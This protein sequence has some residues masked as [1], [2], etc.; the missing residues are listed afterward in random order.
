MKTKKFIS[1]MLITIG[2]FTFISCSRMVTLVKVQSFEAKTSRLDLATAFNTV[3]MLLVDRGF[4]IKASNK[5]AGLIT[6]EYKKFASVGGDPP[7]DMYLQIKTTIRKLPKGEVVVKMSPI[8]KEQ[9]RLNAA[10]F[11]EHELTYYTG[12]QKNV[13]LIKS[14]RIKG[15]QAKGQVMFMNVVNDVAS[16]LGLSVD[17]IKQNITE[18]QENAFFK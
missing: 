3:T 5:E 14:M 6:T 16:A 8:V 4:D 11:T 17:D 7:F 2:L 1:W 12:D 15:W 10:A 9:N 18:E 13:Q